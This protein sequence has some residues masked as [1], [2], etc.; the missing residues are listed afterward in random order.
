MTSAH[1]TGHIQPAAKETSR[2]SDWLQQNYDNGDGLKLLKAIEIERFHDHLDG[3]E[4][5]RLKRLACNWHLAKK[6]NDGPD[7]ESWGFPLLEDFWSLA[8][9]DFRTRYELKGGWLSYLQRLAL[10]EPQW[11]LDWWRWKMEGRRGRYYDWRRGYYEDDTEKIAKAIIKSI[12]SSTNGARVSNAVATAIDSSK[13][14]AAIAMLDWV[15]QIWSPIAQ[16]QLT[17]AL[18]DNGEQLDAVLRPYFDEKIFPTKKM[19]DGGHSWSER[20]DQLPPSIVAATSAMPTRLRYGVGFAIGVRNAE[21]GTGPT[22]EGTGAGLGDFGIETSE[23]VIAAIHPMVALWALLRKIADYESRSWSHKTELRGLHD[24][25]ARLAAAAPEPWA[26]ALPY[27]LARAESIGSVAQAVTLE[28]SITNVDVRRAL[29]LCAQHSNEPIRLLARG[30]IALLDGIGSPNA[31]AARNLADAAARFIDG[32]PIFPHPLAPMSSI[33]IGSTGIE[34]L[35][36]DGIRRAAQRF[37]GEVRDQSGDIEETLTKALLKEIE[38]EFRELKSRQSYAHLD[39]KGTGPSLLSLEQRPTSKSVEEPECGCDIAWIVRSSVPGR[40]KAAWVDLVQVKKSKAF[41]A[42]D[43][44]VKQLDAW[45]IDVQQLDAILKYSPTAAYWMVCAMGEVLAI[46]A[47]HLFAVYFA[48]DSGAQQKSFTVGYHEVRMAAISIEQ[49]VTDLLI[50]QWLGT[51]DEQL[52]KFVVEGN[53]RIRP[54]VVVEVLIS[55]GK[56][57]QG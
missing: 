55:V 20:I 57:S 21:S 3:E 30:L 24:H 49:Y 7:P 14:D 26:E 50:G 27:I 48:R 8:S 32:K 35:L 44:T 34:T 11:V 28:L 15:V 41:L 43:G 23:V 29:D 38:F 6:A 25:V 9:N 22:L 46:P 17:E 13:R 16:G 4:A 5:T 53:P 31:D 36:R 47:K 51:V 1:R 10:L 12:A 54:R 18:R 33:W 40:H 39:G 56:E 19:S 37:A 52:V 2:L 45:K 42:H